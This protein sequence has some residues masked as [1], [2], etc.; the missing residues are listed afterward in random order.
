M[1]DS[2]P[3]TANNGVIADGGGAGA[4]AD[5]FGMVGSGSIGVTFLYKDR[6]H[7]ANAPPLMP[8]CHRCPGHMACHHYSVASSLLLSRR[9]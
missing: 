1:C 9:S 4:S 3:G 2:L 6:L 7:S 8:L 5:G